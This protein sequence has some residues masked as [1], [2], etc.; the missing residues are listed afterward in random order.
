MGVDVGKG[1][2]SSPQ[3]V[4][5]F[6]GVDPVVFRL[7]AVDRL[8]IDGMSQHEGQALLRAQIGDPVPGEHALHGD[9][10]VV[11][12]GS[13]HGEERL[14]LGAEVFVDRDLALLV[15]DA[16]VDRSRVQVDS[17]VILVLQGVETHPLSSFRVGGF[18]GRYPTDGILQ[19]A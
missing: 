3:E 19:T 2:V 16:H 13:D 4:G 6:V 15:E 14:R 1:H 17:A 8:H 18:P 5:D 12:V 11:P 10:Q 9:D 7:A